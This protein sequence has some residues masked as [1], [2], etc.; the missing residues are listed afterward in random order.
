MPAAAWPA[1]VRHGGGIERKLPGVVG[2][3]ALCIQ[4]E[5]GRKEL[6][7]FRLERDFFMQ[8]HGD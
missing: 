1:P 5:V 7:N 2:R 4:P 3:V 6:A 8:A